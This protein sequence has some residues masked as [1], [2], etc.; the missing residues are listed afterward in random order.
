MALAGICGIAESS[1]MKD[2]SFTSAD[3]GSDLYQAAQ[4]FENNYQLAVPPYANP[5]QNIAQLQDNCQA[6]GVKIDFE[7]GTTTLGFRFQGGVLLAVD[8]RATGGQFIGSQT[9]KKVDIIVERRSWYLDANLNTY[10][11]WRSMITCWE[12]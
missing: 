1:Y 3:F 12:H 11:W 6:N 9:M 4:N 7:H 10:R 5:C 2:A 8:S